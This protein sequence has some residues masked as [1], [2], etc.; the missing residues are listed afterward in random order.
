VTLEK[1]LASGSHT[2][3]AIAT[4]S[5][6]TSEEVATT[7]SVST[8]SITIDNG[9]AVVTRDNEPTVRG[10]T[11]A[12][13]GTTVNVLI[14]DT[15]YTT[16][17]S[18]GRWTVGVPIEQ[19]LAD[20]VYTVKA[21]VGS[22]VATQT[23]TIDTATAV[24]IV[25]PADGS[26]S[27]DNRPVI[28]GT[29]ENS[30][31][32]DLNINSGSIVV[33][34]TADTNGDWSYQ[35]S[36]PLSVATYT[37]RVTASDLYGNEAQATS[38]FAV[39]GADTTAPTVTNTTPVDNATG[40]AVTSNLVLTFSENVTA[41]ANKVVEI[42]KTA[43]NS[44]V[45]SIAVTDAKVTVSDSTVTI[46]PTDNF[47]SETE[48]YVLVEAGAFVDTATNAYAGITTATA[49]SFTTGDATAPTVN[50]VT[51]ST[52]N[53]TYGVGEVIT[54]TISFSEAVTVTGT[55][56]L[57]LETGTT[58]RAA[59][60][61]SG[62]GSNTLSFTYTVQAGDS[63]GD[64][65]YTATTS[66]ALA[67]GTIR[68]VSSNPA[69]LTLATPG[70]T[71]SLG[72][73]K[74]IVIDT[75]ALEANASVTG[76]LY[77]ATGGIVSGI[78]V[79]VGNEGGFLKKAT[80]DNTGRYTI[81]GLPADQVTVYV[82]NSQKIL[83][84][85]VDP[86]TLTNGTV[87]TVDL[88]L[89]D[90]ANIT[91]T[92]EPS[93]LVGD[94]EST[95]LLKALVVY[96]DT[97]VA[98]P[99]LPVIF[100]TTSGQLSPDPVSTNSEGVATSTLSSPIIEGI[101][102]VTG[103]AEIIV[104]DL[105]LG[106]F[107]EK[108]LAITFVPAAI[109]GIVTI[110]GKPVAGARV[111]I[112][113]D[114]GP[115]IGLYEITV[116]TGSDGR[117]SLIVP[118]GNRTYTLNISAEI[119]VDGETVTITLEQQAVV[120]SIGQGQSVAAKRQIS[121][122]LFVKGNLN[123]DISDILGVDN[124]V[125]GK[126]YDADGNLLDKTVT[127]DSEG[128]YKVDELLSGT[129]RLLFQLIA[130]NG[131][132]LAGI[133]LTV[134]VTD[135]G[136]IAIEPGLIDPYGIVTD[137]VTQAPI[138]GID[139]KLYWADT[140][141]NKDKGRTPHTL[142]DLPILADFD[143]N[144]NRNPQFT[145]TTG[146]YAWMVYAD[147]D[148]YL[149]G[150][151]QGYVHYDSRDEGRTVPVKPGEDSWITDGII[152]VGESIVEYNFSMTPMSAPSGNLLLTTG[153]ITET[154]VNLEWNT[155]T[156]AVYYNLYADSQFMATVTGITYTVNG[157][158]SG[159]TYQF[160][161]IAGNDVGQS[162]QSNTV[163]ITTAS[164][165]TGKDFY[166]YSLPGQ[167][168]DTV[169][170]AVNGTIS[171][172]VAHGTD[173]TSLIPTFT[174]SGGAVTTVGADIQTSGVTGHSYIQ[175]L[176]YVVTAENGTTKTWTV[177]VS[178][179]T[180]D[181]IN[182]DI[183]DALKKLKVRYQQGDIWES[184]TL[185]I[186]LLKDGAHSTVVGWTSNKPSVIAIEAVANSDDPGAPREFIAQVH[187][188]AEDVSVILTA[189]V[190]KGPG[191]PLSRTF[192]LIVKSDRIDE[193]KSTVSRGNS[194]VQVGG[195]DVAVDVNR[196]TLSNGSKIDKL[197]ISSA[198]MDQLLQTS[199]Q[200]DQLK[201]HFSDNPSGDIAQRAD[202]IAMELPINALERLNNTIG[203][204]LSTPEGSIRLTPQT[205]SQMKDAGI[206]LFFRIVPIRN[207]GSQSVI[208]D[209]T[210]NDPGV[211]S[212]AGNG[213]V[214]VLDIP[215]T[216][217]TNYTGMDTD[218]TLPLTHMTLPTDPVVLQ[219]FLDSLRVFIQH[220][221]GTKRVVRGSGQND[222][223]G[224]IVYDD[225]GSPI[226]IQ[227]T[228]TKF[229]TFTIFQVIQPAPPAA[230]APSPVVVADPIKVESTEG[231]IEE[232]TVTVV[233]TDPVSYYDED[234]FQVTVGGVKVDIIKV[235]HVNGTLMIEL[236]DPIPAGYQVVI[237]YDQAAAKEQDRLKALPTFKSIFVNEAIHYKYI[238]G[239]TDGQFRPS[240][241]I[242]RAE[243]AAM[244]ARLLNRDG[245]TALPAQ[246]DD[247]KPTHWA[248]ASIQVM[249][250]AEIMFGY[251]NGTFKP[252]QAVSRGEIAVVI[253][254]FMQYQGQAIVTS[255]SG[256]TFPDIANHWARNEIEVLKE[257][258]VF[259]GE[260]LTGDFEPS[261]HGCF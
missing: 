52:A 224:T 213:T 85:T 206:D 8:T 183:K 14:G 230:P 100:T 75:A 236:A 60:Y 205:L 184:I 141:L 74:A 36:D 55:P 32:I 150:T 62:S 225:N 153:S 192:L 223:P 105:E 115:P 250:D 134:V 203:L 73:N 64:L 158:T 255:G 189:T 260:G 20:G 69:V 113:E 240:N 173:L 120:G 214:N 161:V 145:T 188:Q 28:S 122:K 177:T 22:A 121:G 56:T 30:A 168:G 247:V 218:V 38:T 42:R 27:T 16:T 254:R 246:Y 227:F 140:Q 198:S 235:E 40:V 215:R 229:S 7:Y 72:A 219:E 84:S 118:L 197:I 259:R 139:M 41:V 117:Y 124:P 167:V 111:T 152:H 31:T 1:P 17:A 67:D 45:E 79:K 172:T 23:L 39:L 33:A 101:L 78:D 65:D 186:F 201:I 43:D 89:P 238:N 98:I 171:L 237:S 128:R 154:S 217:E 174:V 142:V 187:R 91:L 77:S 129:Y 93:S 110:N 87:V 24:A 159:T 135:A 59:S 175:P 248:A 226:G 160:Y 90:L 242:T 149:A 94:G 155:V 11:N 209:E 195:Q 68:D 49:W 46:N 190:S 109:E 156:N 116:T 253:Q 179:E 21:T 241:Q 70:A 6:G 130:P 132:K 164:L 127:I 252:D 4:N 15:T 102:P 222:I 170:D 44:L 169:I 207:E 244:L 232:G 47:T 180:I 107:A 131:E 249:L 48:Y 10:S 143:P 34:L 257:I 137:R 136:E 103:T 200:P 96:K 212:A 97:Q 108:T 51:S 162:N 165:Q 35:P 25:T 204:N 19:P 146:E 29:A 144:Q 80:T 182:E 86:V 216:I 147:G 61:A 63:T 2:I 123:K 76:I 258:G 196:T 50:N 12:T 243:V 125:S 112:S 92:A 148:Y 3:K 239:Y 54:V 138:P 37:I 191:T 99:Q 157:L 199:T 95:S 210:R 251:N 178:A 193:A 231:A 66:L 81:T 233:L 194:T 57:T 163:S 245:E 220:S 234:A 176:Q 185:P 151:K 13:N 82:E 53:G 228:I 26:S 221:D 88:T 133:W 202:E 104:R 9:A 106:I 83:A 208:A 18:N 58:D 261:W 211:I 71:N 119:I 181:E 126:I 166:T 256:G 114:L 5:Y